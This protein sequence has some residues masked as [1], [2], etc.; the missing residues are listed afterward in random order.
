MKVVVD[1]CRWFSSALIALAVSCV[2]FPCITI[3][4]EVFDLQKCLGVDDDVCWLALL[5]GP[6]LIVVIHR[7]FHRRVWVPVATLTGGFVLSGLGVFCFVSE[8]KADAV[9]VSTGPFS[10]VEHWFGMVLGMLV[11]LVAALLVL[12]AILALVAR[13]IGRSEDRVRP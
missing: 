6:A 8:R 13:R 1:I 2:V 7:G 11:I 12:G 9:H 10:G 5:L 4:Y 3:A